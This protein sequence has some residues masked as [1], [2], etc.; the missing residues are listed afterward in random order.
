MGFRAPFQAGLVVMAGIALAGCAQK[1]A[2][3]QVHEDRGRAIFA[4][5]KQFEG[6]AFGFVRGAAKQYC[7]SIA[8]T[9]EPYLLGQVYT[10]NGIG[11]AEFQCAGANINGVQPPTLPLLSR[12]ET[13]RLLAEQGEALPEPERLP[14]LR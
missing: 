3:Q 2:I 13:E 1:L 11:Y 14:P 6:P 5:D 4:F 8:L 10:L 9:L 12:P 7:Q